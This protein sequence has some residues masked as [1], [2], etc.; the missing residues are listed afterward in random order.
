MVRRAAIIFLE[1]FVFVVRFFNLMRDK[2]SSGVLSFAFF[3]G[4]GQILWG[5]EDRWGLINYVNLA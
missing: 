4:C 1:S 2:T 3:Q 5:E